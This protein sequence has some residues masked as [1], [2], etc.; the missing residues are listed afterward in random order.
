MSLHVRRNPPNIRVTA[1]AR[2]ETP[3]KQTDRRPESITLGVHMAKHLLTDRGVRNAKPAA[4]SYRL[5]DGDGLALWVSATG[6]R[7]WQLRYRLGGKEQTATLGKLDRLTLAEARL[8][9]DKQ[10]KL[11]AKGVHL[12]IAKRVDRAT[13]AVAGARTFKGLAAAWIASEGARKGWT[14]AYR[15]E[16]QQSLARHLRGL[17]ALPVSA[18]VAAITAP[19]LN[20]VE[21][22][23]PAMEEKVSRRL[24]AIMDYAVETGAIVANPLPRRRR[25]KRDRPHFPA[26]TKLPEVGAILRAARAA[27]P[28][29][30]IARAHL[31]LVFTAQR[32]SEVVGATWAEFDLDAQDWAIPRERMK[33]K[34]QSRGPHVVPLAPALLA[35]L[36]EWRAIDGQGT[37]Y[38]CPAPRDPARP[39]T[40][41]GVEKFYRNVLDL[42]GKHSPHSWRSAFSTI[43]READK[44]GDVVEAQLD[45]VVGNKIAAAYDRAKRLQ[46]RRELMR[47]YEAQLI[48]ARDGAAIVAIG[49]QSGAA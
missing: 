32:V 38:V 49:R 34:D 29:K 2:A 24:H 39:I 5:F 48:A 40:P 44:D 36:K 10:R 11:A 31:L 13:R 28:C 30:G 21:K 14:A 19:M 46:L 42:A 9:A 6:A 16:V 8:E 18:I 17:D 45:H 22:N 41:E 12:T 43:A 25:A 33:R 7:S 20:L 3:A 4:K 1:G 26:A 27:D 15:A 37:L 23:A 35:S 47:W